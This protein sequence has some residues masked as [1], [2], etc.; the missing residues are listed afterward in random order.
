MTSPSK[1]KVT[2]NL[3]NDVVRAYRLAAVRQGVSDQTIIER[4]VREYLGLNALER[5]QKAFAHLELNET[6]ADQLA[7]E[8]V[9]ETRKARRKA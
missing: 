5:L 8:V 7:V 9:R 2:L 3:P 4:A 6:Q 1:Q